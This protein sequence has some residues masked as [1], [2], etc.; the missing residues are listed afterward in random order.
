MNPAEPARSA[1]RR[2]GGF[3]PVGLGER[4][5][6][7]LPP[8]NLAALLEDRRTPPGT[9]L[10]V[11]T[12][13]SSIDAVVDRIRDASIECAPSSWCPEAIVAEAPVRRLQEVAGWADGDFHVQSPSSIAAGLVLDPQPG[14]WVL[15]L[16]AAPGSKTS[17]LA[18]LMGNEGRLVA[19]DLSRSRAHRL[20]AVLKLLGAEATV[21]VGPGERMGLREPETYD[22][23]LVDA[24]CSGE[25]MMRPGQPETWSN[26]KPRTPT[27]L[28]SRQKSLLHAAIDATRPGGTIVYSTCTFAPEENELVI[29]RALKVYEGK[30]HLEPIPLELPGRVTAC[31]RF[32][33]KRMPDLP[34]VVRLAPPEMEGFFIAK[35]VKTG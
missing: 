6:E 33:E 12:L 10:R 4:L 15:D 11:N 26:W 28:S 8:E 3:P 21:R 34:E 18:A 14:E 2:D 7:L 1:D 32:R 30:L 31:S 27:R 16:C 9:W 20:R 19:N 29:K 22:R 5:E 24:P 23:V 17:H 35:L 13:K 25:G